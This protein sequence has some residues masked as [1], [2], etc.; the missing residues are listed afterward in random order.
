MLPSPI[1]SFFKIRFFLLAR[2]D[3]QF[4]ELG[5]LSP[6]PVNLRRTGGVAPGGD[7]V[8]GAVDGDQGRGDDE[9]AVAIDLARAATAAS[10]ALLPPGQAAA[11]RPQS[12]SDKLVN[13]RRMAV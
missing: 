9:D 13:H 3:D 1:P 8:R 2:L 6:N 12:A 7:R 10:P 5:L 4:Q 11:R